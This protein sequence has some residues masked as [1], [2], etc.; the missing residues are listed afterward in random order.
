MGYPRQVPENCSAGRD[1]KRATRGM[2]DFV[3]ARMDVEHLTARQVG[4]L[5]GIGKS[6]IAYIL[7]RNAE[8]RHPYRLNEINAILDAL[9]IS[10]TDAVLGEELLSADPHIDPQAVLRI[11]K[12]MSSLVTGIGPE[13]F[14]IVSHIEGLEF[15]DIRP[16]H[17]LRLQISLLDLLQRHYSGL[18][19]R[20]E[21]RIERDNR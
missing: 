7:H 9:N 1:E 18:V 6:R 19:A 13:I 5:A 8:L 12:L 14:Q 20:R 21:F 2:V 10:R 15:E 16:E 4:R 17:G 3:L 11:A